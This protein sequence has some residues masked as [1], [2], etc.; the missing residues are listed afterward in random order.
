MLPICV[1]ADFDASATEALPVKIETIMSGITLALSTLAQLGELG[2]NRLFLAAA[3]KVPIRGCP[4]FRFSSVVVLGIT[5][6]TVAICVC[7]FLPSSRPIHSWERPWALL[8]AA[9]PRSEP[10][11]KTGA[12]WPAEWLGIGK[13]PSLAFSEGSPV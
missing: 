4:S 1:L 8:L 7:H 10:P 2:T 6:P 11:R 12:V 5:C 9:M 13:T 3:A